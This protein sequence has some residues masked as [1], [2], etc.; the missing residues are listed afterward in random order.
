MDGHIL[1]ETTHLTHSF[2][3]EICSSWAEQAWAE[4]AQ[5]PLLLL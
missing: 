5:S 4:Q 2:L 1:D 3:R